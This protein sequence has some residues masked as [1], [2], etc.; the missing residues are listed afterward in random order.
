MTALLLSL[1]FFFFSSFYY[2]T[3]TCSRPHDESSGARREEE[4]N[5]KNERI[6]CLCAVKKAHLNSP[7]D[8]WRAHSLRGWKAWLRWTDNV[9]LTT[10]TGLFFLVLVCLE[11]FFFFLRFLPY[12]VNFLFSSLF[13]IVFF[14]FRGVFTDVFFFFLSL[15]VF[16]SLFENTC[17]RCNNKTKQNK[18]EVKK[19]KYLTRVVHAR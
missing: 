3:G 14:F 10:A 11:L 18:K 9:T 16:L 15:S 12:T 2:V 19:A 5:K 1:F 17:V 8:D 13:F 4:E 7:D 6:S